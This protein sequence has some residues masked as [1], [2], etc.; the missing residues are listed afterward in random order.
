MHAIYGNFPSGKAIRNEKEIEGGLSNAQRRKL[1]KN[2]EIGLKKR[3]AIVSKLSK[4]QRCV[5]AELK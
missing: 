3:N 1:E 2:L 4:S 5:C